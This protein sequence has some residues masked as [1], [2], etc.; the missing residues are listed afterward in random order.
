MTT[1]P[2]LLYVAWFAVAG[3][4]IDY[5]VFFPAFRRRSQADPARART[6]LWAW[7]IPGAWALV[8]VGAALWVANDR[9]WASFGFFVPGGW[10]LWT[11]VAVFLLLAAYFASAVA[12]LARSPDARAGAR[13]QVGTLTAVLPHTRTELYWFG[14]VSLTAGFCEEFLFRG[15]FIW[16]LAPWLGWW[17]AA[18]LSAL[19][20]AIGHAYQGWNGVLRTGIVGGFF[21]LAV[22]V[23]NSLWPAI[24]LHAL[25]DLANGTMAWLVLREGQAT[26]DVK[27]AERP[28]ETQTA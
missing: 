3:P 6:W 20:F 28:V 9:S 25:I 19:I 27:T 1:L 26:G 5:V 12:T 2:D 8:A 18:A 22:A 11:S 7:T 13:Q 17:G 24:A 16:A 10:R 21:T 15:Y 14:G 4:V 23:F